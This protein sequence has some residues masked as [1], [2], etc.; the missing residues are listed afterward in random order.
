MQL[1]RAGHFKVW[2]NKGM[3]KFQTQKLVSRRD[4]R[5]NQLI[6][7]AASIAL[8]SG[9]SAISVAA[10]A[11]RAGLSRTSVYEYFASSSELVADLVIDELESFAHLLFDA[12]AKCSNY[13]CVISC[14]INAA[15]TYIADGRHLLAKSLNAISMPT[16]RADEISLAHRRLL[17]SLHEGLRQAG[18]S[19][20]TRELSYIQAITDVSAKRIEAGGNAQ[21][22]ISYATS[23]CTKAFKK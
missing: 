11:Q 1:N 18:L 6:A 22:E 15:L 13:E 12:V 16:S 10:V 5:R 20:V 14:W 23:F 7:A 4:L 19:D 17:A 2:Q 8:E 9:G 21:E 3:A